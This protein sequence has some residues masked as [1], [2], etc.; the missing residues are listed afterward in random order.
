M[1][2]AAAV[3]I[4]PRPSSVGKWLLNPYLLIF[5]GALL[6]SSGEVLLKMGAD[7]VANGPH[8]TGPF[9]F[10]APLF[11]GWTW[12]GIISYIASLLTWLYVLRTVPLSVA[13][14]LINVVHVLVPTG[15]HLFLHEVI[16]PRLWAGVG[17]I[18]AGVLVIARPLMQAE[19]KL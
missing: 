14:P 1:T 17:L 12:I 4:T 3:R 15:A 10:A 9:G 11:C 18:M 6:D 19:E 5:V 2:D 16:H 13:F 8:T 7:V